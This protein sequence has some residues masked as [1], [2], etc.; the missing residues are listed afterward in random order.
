MSALDD[1]GLQ[2]EQEDAYVQQLALSQLLRA[3]KESCRQPESDT[4][5]DNNQS[6]SDTDEE[7]EREEAVLGQQPVDEKELAS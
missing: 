2:D 7:E 1:S 6:D 5:S 4:E 3:I